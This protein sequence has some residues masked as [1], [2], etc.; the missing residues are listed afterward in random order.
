M[1]AS[2]VVLAALDIVLRERESSADEQSPWCVRD[3]WRINGRYVRTFLF[4]HGES[5]LSASVEYRE[6]GFAIS[7]GGTSV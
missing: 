1:P 7:V 3:G 2:A 5:E 4:M 6:S